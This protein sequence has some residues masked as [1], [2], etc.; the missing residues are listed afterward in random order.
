MSP[1]LAVVA[2]VLQPDIGVL[3]GQRLGFGES[4]L[5]TGNLGTYCPLDSF[6]FGGIDDGDGRGTWLVCNLV[7]CTFEWPAG[8]FAFDDAGV[9]P[10]ASRWQEAFEEFSVG[11]FD[12]AGESA[13]GK[14]RL[15]GDLAAHDAQ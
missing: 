13:G 14:R 8:D 11:G 15:V 12:R 10:A 1:D 7:G 5:N 6:G 3:P 4:S 2:L 9:G